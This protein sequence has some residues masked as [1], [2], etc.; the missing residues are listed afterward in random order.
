MG[1]FG[2][3]NMLTAKDLISA[4][5]A[6]L[7][8]GRAF[9]ARVLELESTLSGEREISRQLVAQL[10]TAAET[11]SASIAEV[12]R[13]RVERTELEAQTQALINQIKGTNI[14]A[15]SDAVIVAVQEDT[16]TETPPVVEGV[17]TAPDLVPNDIVVEA[18]GEAIADALAIV[19]ADALPA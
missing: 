18:A 17:E 15:A 8:Q 5:L 12:D 4:L 9:Q 6:E 1:N 14:T 10:Q 3:K 7:E 2:N 19:E 16:D 13:L 11:G